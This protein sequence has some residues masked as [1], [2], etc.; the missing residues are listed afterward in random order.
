MTD[1]DAWRGDNKAES[2][3]FPNYE[4]DSASPAINRVLL[5][6]RGD[7]VAYQRGQIVRFN[8]MDKD[9]QGVKK[10][11]IKR[12]DMLVE[13]IDKPGTG[14]IERAF[15]TCDDYTA[16]CV[17]A[18]DSQSQTCEF[19]VCDL[20]FSFPAKKLALGKSWKIKFTS[21]NMK[22]VFVYFYSDQNR[23]NASYVFIT[24]EDRRKGSVVIP[25]DQVRD[26]GN[27][28]VWLFGENTYGRLK[29]RQ[30]IIVEK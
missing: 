3:L 17:M 22:I 21:D 6:D 14:V 25:G 16:Y 23:Y 13:E 7:W 10:L 15:S 19:S 24:D 11:I 27:L 18:D 1:F 20:D 8:I 26:S 28:Q 12:G 2:F 30:D 9:A 29:K 4:E 5:L